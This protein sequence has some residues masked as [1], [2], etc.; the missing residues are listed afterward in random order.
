MNYKL[1]DCF[2]KTASD[3]YKCV[4]LGE[5]CC[6]AHSNEEKRQASE[7]LEAPVP[8]Q[9]PHPN[10]GMQFY[11]ELISEYIKKPGKEE[12][13]TAL[14]KKKNRK[15]AGSDSEEC[16]K[17]L[18]PTAIKKKQNVERVAV[19]LAETQEAKFQKLQD[20]FESIKT[21]P[22]ITEYKRTAIF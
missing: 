7:V 4:Q 9:L 20:T 11:S 17:V 6:H 8:K 15:N 21:S 3:K 19:H 2:N 13:K 16:K 10:E 12:K 14:S 5:L 22:A 18:D 1:N